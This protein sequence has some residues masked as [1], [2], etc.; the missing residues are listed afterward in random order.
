MTALPEGWGLILDRSVQGFCDGTVLAGGRPG[1]LVTLTPAGARA[2]EDLL[3]GRGAPDAAPR[4]L[5][6]RLV[7]AGMAHPRPPARPGPTPPLT[8]VVPVRDRSEALAR[9]LAAL[10]GTHPVVVVDDASADPGAVDRVCRAHGARRVHREANG[11]PGAARTTGMAACA[12]DLVAF[13]DSDVTVPPGW[14]DHLTW[15]F[16]DPSVAAVAQI[17]RASCRERV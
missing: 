4:A 2:L 14:L 8:V 5:A 12:T 9:C 6:G 10:G 7:A 16:E 17:G 1:R 11:G 15:C 3:V 13:V